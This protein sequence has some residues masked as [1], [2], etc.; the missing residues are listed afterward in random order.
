MDY[1]Y[2][3][4]FISQSVLSI[5]FKLNF[6]IIPQVVIKCGLSIICN[7]GIFLFAHVGII[8]NIQLYIFEVYWL[9]HTFWMP[10][11]Q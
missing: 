5:A 4:L 6:K 2:L 11:I 1:T 7:T 3:G 10:L 9:H 8:Y